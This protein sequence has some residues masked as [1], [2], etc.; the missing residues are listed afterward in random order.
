MQY[1]LHS[2]KIIPHIIQPLK[3]GQLLNCRVALA[4]ERSERFY[5]FSHTCYLSGWEAWF[6]I[7]WL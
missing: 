2:I 3:E 6:K 1:N 4:P 5:G 7:F